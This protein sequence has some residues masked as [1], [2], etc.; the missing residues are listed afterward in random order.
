MMTTRKKLEECKAEF[1]PSTKLMKEVLGDE[2]EKVIVSLL[3]G[4]FH[5]GLVS[6]T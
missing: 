5:S 1:E 2:T 3:S 6:Y 4:S